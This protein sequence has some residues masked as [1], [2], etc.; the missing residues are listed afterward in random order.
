MHFPRFLHLPSPLTPRQAAAIGAAYGLLY[1]LLD[2]LSFIHLLPPF[3][4]TPWNPPPGLTLALILIAGMRFLPLALGVCWLS[5][6]L[7]HQM[8]PASPEPLVLAAVV[9]GGY[10]L[11]AW[12]LERWGATDLRK[13]SGLTRF[14]AL[15]ALQALL[16]GAGFLAGAFAFMD[17]L[18]GDLGPALLRYWVG[19]FIGILVTTPLILTLFH[20]GDWRFVRSKEFCL[21]CLAVL[22]SLGLVFGLP[23]ADEFKNFYLLFLPLIWISLRHGLEGACL[24]VAL[25]QVGLIVSVQWLGYTGGTVQGL[26][27]LMAC[28]AITG[29]TLGVSASARKGAEAELK[30]ALRLTAA[31][32]M[33]AALAHEL[34]QPL[35][36][37]AN[38]ARAGQLLLESGDTGALAAVLEKVDRESRRAG[39]V[40]RRLRDFFQTGH[41]RQDPVTVLALVT[42]TCR[43]LEPQAEAQGTRLEYAVPT[44]LPPLRGDLVQLQV[45]LRNLVANALEAVEAGAGGQTPRVSLVAHRAGNMIEVAVQDNGP[46]IPAQFRGRLFEPFT[47]SKPTGMGLGLAIS[48]A[49]AKAHGGRLWVE[50]PSGGGCRFCLALPVHPSAPSSTPLP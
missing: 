3:D 40:V 33:A 26:Q 28:L 9:T 34:N 10:G 2:W 13:L 18:P 5:N 21:Q 23:W 38:Y 15:L 24:S 35:T 50:S 36:A 1:L 42:Q 27:L 20:P 39:D 49:I 8:D 14:I 41:T 46:G 11:L 22:L 16:V 6:I 25:I 17:H 7:V 43:D 32:E 37:V 48:R 31:G 12:L 47:T 19:D 4:V 45:V 30:R 44:D 29:L